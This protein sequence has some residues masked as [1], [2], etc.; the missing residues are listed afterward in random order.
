MFAEYNYQYFPYVIVTFQENITNEQ[1]FDQFL[2][3]WLQLY[4]RQQNFYFIFDTTK[5]GFVNPKYCLMMS[6]FIKNLRQRPYQYLQKSYIIVG[7]QLIEKLLDMIFY[8]QPPVAPVYV[9]KQTLPEV[10]Q[11]IK[12]SYQMIEFT[13]VIYPKKPL[14]PFL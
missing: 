10:L 6:S 7:S 8:L 14:L 5:M 2:L 9:T 3:E 13:R 12:N 4:E 11:F 1:E